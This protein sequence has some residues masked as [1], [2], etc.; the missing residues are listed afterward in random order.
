MM[1]LVARAEI[2]HEEEDPSVTQ[3]HATGRGDVVDVLEHP[4]R[5]ALMWY[6]CDPGVRRVTSRQAAQITGLSMSGAINH[7]NVM[8]RAGFVDRRKGG[9]G[10]YYWYLR[11]GRDACVDEDL[12]VE[13]QFDMRNVHASPWAAR[14]LSRRIGHAVGLL[15]E[16]YTGFRLATPACQLAPEDRTMP[17]RLSVEIRPVHPWR[18]HED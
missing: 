12:G 3:L 11:H 6:F 15:A 16:P 4:A 18:V 1:S 7:L 9:T 8:R 17:F 14:A 2:D 10:P 5:L 13:M